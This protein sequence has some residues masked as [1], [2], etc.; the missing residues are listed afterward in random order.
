[1]Q[2]VGTSWR[3]NLFGVL[4]QSLAVRQ[5]YWKLKCVTVSARAGRDRAASLP[6]AAQHRP[7]SLLEFLL[8]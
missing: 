3:L 2:Q 4:S 1:M 7:F 8:R 5:E 6:A